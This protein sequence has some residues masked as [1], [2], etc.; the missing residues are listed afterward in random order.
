MAE[1]T[2][3]LAKDGVYG[4]ANGSYVDALDAIPDSAL[5]HFPF[6]ERTDSTLVEELEGA[7]GTANGLTNVSG[8]W[9]SG[10]AEDGDGTDDYGDLS[11][12]SEVSYPSRLTSDWGLALT[13]QTTDDGVIPFGT[14]EDSNNQ[15]FRLE[16]GV[17]GTP[18]GEI[19]LFV[20]DASSQNAQVFGTGQT[21]N[22]G[23]IH[24]LLIGGDGPAASDKVC[25]LD[26]SDVT[27][28]YTDEG[29]HNSF[30]PFVYNIYSHARNL[31]GSADLFTNI[32]L[33]NIIPLGSKPT[34]QVAADDY[35]AQPWS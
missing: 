2:Y 6:G 18:S 24:R 3:A 28:V 13:F 16:M 31:Q 15:T 35:N 1:Q 5:L 34:S 32:T 10:Y 7:D 8:D 17:G 23:N 27:T 9:W 11:D 26:G 20:R 25:Y 12:W 33:D 29:D 22:D 14:Q 4:Q 30:D 19:G 21:V